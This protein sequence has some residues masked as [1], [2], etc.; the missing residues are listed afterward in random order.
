MTDKP[1][2]KK[3]EGLYELIEGIEIAMMTTVRQDGSLVTRPMATQERMA[4]ADMWFV[5]D[6]ESEKIGEVDLDPRVSLA[7]YKDYEW[8][9]VSGIGTISTDRD[10][11]RELYKPDWKM[12]FGDEGGARDGGPDDPRLALVLVD[13]TSVVYG[14]RNK[15]KP[16][17]LFEVVKGLVTGEEPEVADIERISGPEL[18]RNP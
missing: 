5:T 14:K 9:S 18:H 6:A 2:N 12:W 11:I 15:S 17:A 4:G 1:L 7:Y 16:L 8:V 10:M 3:I 13:A